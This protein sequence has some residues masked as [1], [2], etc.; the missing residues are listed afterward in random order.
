MDLL[1]QLVGTSTCKQPSDETDQEE[2]G[3]IA[4]PAV[5]LNK[6][7]GLKMMESDVNRIDGNIAKPNAVCKT[8]EPN[9]ENGD[10]SP[11]FG[12]VESFMLKVFL[13]HSF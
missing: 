10:Y 5:G 2:I 4:A 11:K 13:L 8:E 12:I 1:S 9:L 3:L 6:G 7:E